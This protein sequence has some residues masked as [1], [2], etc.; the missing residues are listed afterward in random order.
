MVLFCSCSVG[1]GMDGM[2]RNVG[3]CGGV[4]GGTGSGFRRMAIS[5]PCG[6]VGGKCGFAR[7]AN[8]YLAAHPL[9]GR[10]DGFAGAV[11]FRPLLLE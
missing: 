5:V 4:A 3:S 2:A 10:L 6:R 8:F 9:A 11:V 1:G 7:L